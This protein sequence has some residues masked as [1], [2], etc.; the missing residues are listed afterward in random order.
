MV[1]D[2]K[3]S[4]LKGRLGIVIETLSMEQFWGLEWEEGPTLAERQ[5]YMSSG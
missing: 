4:H 5:V 2:R 3:K 1:K